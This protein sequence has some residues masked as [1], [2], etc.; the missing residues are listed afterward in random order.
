MPI[1]NL[2]SVT[3]TV[4]EKTKMD[5]A[6][7]EQKTVMAGKSTNL[8]PK[9]K[10]LYGSINEENKLMV[11]KVLQYTVTNPE[12]LP[13]HVDKP[14]LDRDYSG[15][16][17]LDVWEDQLTLMLSNVQNA[18]I[19]LDYDVF[20]TCLSIYRN[21]RYKA[22]EDVPGMSAIYNDL[23]QFFPGGGNTTAETTTPPKN[24]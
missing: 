18:K 11:Q 5:A 12:V 2:S 1:V 6:I 8:T 23:K 17:A 20:Q 24:G 15:R 4:A 10:Q 9:E 16:N 3:F 21:V 19:L 14:E 7:A 13:E 22:G